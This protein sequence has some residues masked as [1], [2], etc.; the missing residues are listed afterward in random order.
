L[1]SSPADDLFQESGV[2][3][4]RVGQ[5]LGGLLGLLVLGVGAGLF[6]ASSAAQ[7]RLGKHF[8]A[9]TVEFPVPFPLSAAE[10]A[11]AGAA[12]PSVE[13]EELVALDVAALARERAIA[14]GK[15][16]V[17]SRYA[18]M[19]CHGDN[20]GGGVMVDA[21]P[22]GTLLG[23]NLTLGKGSRT[24]NY[25]VTDWDRMVRHGVRPDGSGSLM[26]SADFFEMSDQELS[27]IVTLIRSKPPV[28]AEV[29]RPKLGPL[30]NVLT[31]TGKMLVSAE[32]KADH[33]APHPSLPP[34]EG[35]TVEFG[36]HLLAVCSG[37]HGENFAGGPIR[38]GDPKW[39]PARNLTPH[40]D[41]LK[42]WSYE[43]FAAALKQARRPDGTP[44][45]APMSEMVSFA[46]RSSET[47]LKATWRALQAL[48][49]LPTSH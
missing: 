6:W 21:Q 38:G 8:E 44:L 47:E 15:H 18:C 37:C 40:A 49:P 32:L 3:M 19:A 9:H 16:L 35:D 26:P 23:T 5:V 31:A 41:G 22:L 1:A 33:R 2:F 12:A 27:D 7:A 42:G 39:P 17:E 13:G 24:A 36:K 45:R 14:R 4:K 20:F 25:T 34:A 28:D 11:A 10:L 29:P 46:Q 48:P 30:G 43:D